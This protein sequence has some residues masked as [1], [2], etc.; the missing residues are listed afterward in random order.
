[1][2]AWPVIFVVLGILRYMQI[3]FVEQKSGSPTK[4]LIRDLFLQLVILGWLI[5]FAML[6]PAAHELIFGWVG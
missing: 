3:T 1:M 5:S 4:V 6:V 2:R